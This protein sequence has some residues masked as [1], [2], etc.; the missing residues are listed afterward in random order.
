MIYHA[1]DLNPREFP[2]VGDTI[3]LNKVAYEVSLS[4]MGY[5]LHQ[6]SKKNMKIGLHPSMKSFIAAIQQAD[7]WRA[8]KSEKSVYEGVRDA[9]T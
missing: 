6:D 4:R 9:P 8:P 7:M 1:R 5:Y 3:L 2:I